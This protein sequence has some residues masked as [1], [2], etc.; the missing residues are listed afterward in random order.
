MQ[1]RYVKSP[2]V[3]SLLCL[4]ANEPQLLHHFTT[5]ELGYSLCFCKQ[6]LGGL[7]LTE[8]GHDLVFIE[9]IF[10]ISPQASIILVN[11]RPPLVP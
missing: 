10:L 2:Y 9:Q 4:P 1:M 5:I 6:V 7:H 3:S 11:L 8:R